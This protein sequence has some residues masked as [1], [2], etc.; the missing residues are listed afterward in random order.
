[1]AG[2]PAIALLSADGRITNDLSRVKNE[3][4]TD[5]NAESEP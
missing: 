3:E 1:M 5:P 2:A 4:P